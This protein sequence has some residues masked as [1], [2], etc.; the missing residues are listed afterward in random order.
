NTAL[1]LLAKLQIVEVLPDQQQCRTGYR[2][3]LLREWEEA[4]RGQSLPTITARL[5][6][7]HVDA[8]HPGLRRRHRRM[9][10]IVL[11]HELDR[12]RRREPRRIGRSQAVDQRLVSGGGITD[13]GAP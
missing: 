10:R 11:Q 6:L 3:Q 2:R 5:E 12:A 4:K 1:E 9:G 7:C 8:I 13:S